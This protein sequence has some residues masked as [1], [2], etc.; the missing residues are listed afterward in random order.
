MHFF[1][2]AFWFLGCFPILQVYFSL[3]LQGSNVIGSQLRSLDESWA[4]HRPAAVA[5][6]PPGTCSC[7]SNQPAIF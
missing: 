1:D 6:V 3:F 4:R 5:S 7:I 2:V